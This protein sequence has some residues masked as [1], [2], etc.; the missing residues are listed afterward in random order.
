MQEL[1][2]MY[3]NLVIVLGLLLALVMGW[4]IGLGLMLVYL[5][6]KVSM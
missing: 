5:I 4:N 1:V 6:G 3:H 2:T